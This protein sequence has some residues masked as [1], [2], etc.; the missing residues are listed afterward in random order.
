MDPLRAHWG[1]LIGAS[2]LVLAAAHLGPHFARAP[3]LDENR[4][5]A[6][7]PP[8]PGR[9]GE[10]DA[11]RTAVDAWV[12]DRFPA[13]PHLIGALNHLKMRLGVSGSPRVIVGRDGWLFY[14]DT[15]HLGPARGLPPLTDAQ[16][17]AWLAG[18]A[19]RTEALAARG[20]PYVVISAPDKEI[21]YP[22][23]GPRWYAGPDPNRPAAMLARLAHASGAGAVLRLEEAMARPARWGL[24]LYEPYDTHW[25]GL[26]AYIGYAELMRELQRRGIGEGP[27]PLESFTDVRTDD[28]NKPRNLALMLGVA[29]HVAIDYPELEDPAVQRTLRTTWLTDRHDWT[30]P[31]V[32][33]TGQAGRPVLMMTMDSFSNALL[34][35]LYPHFSRIVLAHNQEGS[36]RQ[37][38]IDRFRPDVVVLEVVENGLDA[39]LSPAP[40]ASAEA[41][42]R[43]NRAVANRQALLVDRV[44]KPGRHIEG[45]E[46]ADRLRGTEAG[47]PIDGRPGDDTL[48]GLGG[49]D[50]LRGGRGRD[51]IDGGLGDDL[52]N[53]GREDDVLTGGPGAD[54]FNSFAGAG[55][56]RVT[57]FDAAAGDLVRIESGV[58]FT[59]RQSG[60]DTVVEMAGARLVLVGVSAAGLPEGAIA[61]R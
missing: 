25:T 18:L 51:V 27:R 14:D 12:A 4:R 33:D 23:H 59:V 26:G 36:W 54:V 50:T 17:R 20:V 35:F 57:D 8:L 24:K 7:A 21:V 49:P 38:L 19:G 40:P 28:P 37:D 2:V 47:E 60:A 46:R 44:L 32:V 11:F 1:R 13:R 9:P 45:G 16:A 15:T 41:L 55:T 39:S 29:G 22:Q 56:D 31:H 6:E 61:N 5:L 30:A 10:L 3:G 34:P 42:A 52:L 53:G 58:A 48:V 43:I